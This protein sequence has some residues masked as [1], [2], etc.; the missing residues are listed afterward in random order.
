MEAQGIG[1]MDGENQQR[2]RIG[3]WS[4]EQVMETSLTTIDEVMDA[5]GIGNGAPMGT[6]GDQGQMEETDSNN[7]TSTPTTDED[8]GRE[9]R[10]GKIP[11]QMAM[12][13]RGD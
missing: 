1:R 3:S 4:Q 5:K 9:K 12:I 2:E 7:Q 8:M 10:A 6:P 13:G 11:R